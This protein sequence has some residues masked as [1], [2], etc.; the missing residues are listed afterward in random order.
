[1]KM[2][3]ISKAKNRMKKSAIDKPLFEKIINNI[4]DILM[5]INPKDYS[6]LTANKE[7]LEKEGFSLS[8]IKGKKCYEITHK[9]A[10]RCLAPHDRCPMLEALKT[11]KVVKA[12]HIHY[13]KDKKEYNVEVIAQPILSSKG[14]V[15]AVVHLSRDITEPRRQEEENRRH[16]EKLRELTLRDPHT[17]AYNYRYLMERLPVEIELSRRHALPLAILIIDIDYFKSI[18]DVYGH[19]V[20]DA[21]LLEFVNL[22]KG[23][24][25][26]SDILTRY[27]GEEFV[28]IMPQ[29]QRR[30]ALYV[31][32]RIINKV[33]TNIFKIE[34]HSIKIKISIG[35]AELLLGWQDR[36]ITAKSLL[37]AVDKALQQAKEAGG[38]RAVVYSH[39]HKDIRHKNGRT[40]YKEEAKNL[41]R[42]LTKLG[43]RV[44]Q[45]VLESMYAFSKSLEA[46]D[47]YTA[48]HAESMIV[49][50]L[51]I[52]KKLGLDENALNNLEKAAVLHDIGKI[53]I[54]DAILQKKGKL[55]P[56]EYKIIQAHP[57][58]GAEIIRTVHFLKEVVPIVMHHH[59]R[60]DGLGYPLGL[61]DEEIPLCAR[62]I[63]IAD[64]YQALISDRPYRKAYSKQGAFKILRQEAGWHFDRKIIKVLI[65]IETAKNKPRKA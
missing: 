11:K 63:A 32:E 29:T 10:T 54:S 33:G 18:N 47:S 22:T 28:V 45:V 57:K 41:K 64:A 58:I 9:R 52:G 15:E 35:V 12:E 51:S 23:L 7:C 16:F 13:D 27:G 43:K 34:N 46:R 55:T 2:K 24:L 36:L 31:A 42:K 39:V 14:E 50:A 30:D 17:W 5:V 1:M 59:E 8:Q 4:P 25:R 49:I 44:D 6:I 60:L 40:D 62:I 65:E 19:Q 56:E 3:K 21:L 53:G 26:K 48:E 20:G 37:D 38:N 61:C